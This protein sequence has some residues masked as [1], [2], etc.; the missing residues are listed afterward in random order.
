M[1]FAASGLPQFDAS[2]FPNVLFWLLVSFGTLYLLVLR[3]GIP[4]IQQVLNAREDRILSDRAQAREL[5]EAAEKTRAEYE[6]QR[7]A[8]QA[9]A[10]AEIRSAQSEAA[11]E[12]AAKL[13]ALT[14]RLNEDQ[15]RSEAELEAQTQEALK[16][17]SSIATALVE[18]AAPRFG[19]Y[20]TRKAQA[21]VLQ[22]QEKPQ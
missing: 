14:Q 19:D 20:D 15:R 6:A 11:K 17:V 13:D 3:S 7:S 9:E 16:S 1:L 12:A 4:G 10:Q 2:T 8:A 5:G 21:L 18:T 22:Q